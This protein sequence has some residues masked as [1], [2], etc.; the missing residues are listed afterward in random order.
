MSAVSKIT[1][2]LAAVMVVCKIVQKPFSFSGVHFRFRP[3][4]AISFFAARM[5]SDP[6]TWVQTESSNL[7]VGSERFVVWMHRFRM[8]EI[9]HWTDS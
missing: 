5:Q 7:Q 4:A 1:L 9:S 6:L 8:Q 2:V 3:A